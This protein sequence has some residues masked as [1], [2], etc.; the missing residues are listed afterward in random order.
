MAMLM[1]QLTYQWNSLCDLKMLVVTYESKG[2][3]VLTAS[4]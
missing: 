3:E 1:Q 2:G 4:Y